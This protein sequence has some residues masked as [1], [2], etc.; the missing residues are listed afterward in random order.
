MFGPP[1][2]AIML[3]DEQHLLGAVCEHLKRLEAALNDEDAVKGID[4]LDELAMHPHIAAALTAAG[5][6][7]HREFAYPG[8]PGK[9]KK[10]PE[11]ERCDFVLTA[12]PDRPPGDPM[13]LVVDREKQEQTLFAPL[14]PPRLEGTPI[15]ECYFLECKVVG[16]YTYV[17]GVPVPN[18]TYASQLTRSVTK[19]LKKLNADERIGF[20]GLL[21]VLFTADAAVAEHDLPIALHRALDRHA[22]FRSPLKLQFPIAERVGNACCTVALIAKA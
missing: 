2:L 21:L 8:I 12:S 15:G 5:I 18:R 17:E 10:K 3:W 13:V 16:Q 4:A 9:R 1:T 7:V 11:R 20:G 19:D 6:C 14:P 22:M